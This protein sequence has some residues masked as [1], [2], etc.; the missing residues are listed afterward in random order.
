MDTSQIN[1]LGDLVYNDRDISPAQLKVTSRQINYWLDNKVLPF[2]ERQQVVE[3]SSI[4]ANEPGGAK[5]A[6][7]TKWVRLNLAQ[8]VW[9]CIVKELLSFG[10]SMEQLKELAHSVW[11][12]P[13]KEKY[14]DKVFRD[15]IAKNLLDEH[16]NAML[17]SFLEDEMAMKHHFRTI[18]NPF[19]DLVKSAILREAIPH[20]MLYVP[21]TNDYVFHSGDNGLFLE[22]GSAF[23]EH[24]MVC[25][26]LM[27]IL[28]KVLAV[29]FGNKKKDLGYLNDIE[30]QIRDIVVFKKPKAVHIAFEEGHI[31]PI[32]VNEQ[33]KSREALSRYILENKI[34]K[35]SKLLIDIRNQD[36]Y[37]ITL[38]KK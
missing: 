20:A 6:T 25:I 16:N 4:K 9:A 27:P 28:S 14:A 17:K 3:N 5:S 11:Q 1:A 38:I 18:I 22:L 23:L 36:N 26:P 30:N 12:K 19:T 21:K 2:V 35:G 7:K 15:H 33:H 31:K 13:R 37:K 32:T 34:A 29:D 10:V 24:P 8:A